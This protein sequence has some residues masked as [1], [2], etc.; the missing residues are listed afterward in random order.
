MERR[1]GHDHQPL[2]ADPLHG[3]LDQKQV[4][5][6]RRLLVEGIV[7]VRQALLQR[8]YL[9]LKLGSGQKNVSHLHPVGIDVPKD[10][11]SIRHE[12][13]ENFEFVL[14]HLLQQGAQWDHA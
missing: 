14:P 11:R 7:G 13:L 10:H 5:L 1:V 6:A 4:Q 12:V 2:T 8:F 3:R 9:C